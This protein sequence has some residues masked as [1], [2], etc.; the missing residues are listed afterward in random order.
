MIPT[1][2]VVELISAFKNND[3]NLIDTHIKKVSE[4]AEK[5][6]QNKLLQKLKKLY[7]SNS[8]TYWVSWWLIWK[9]NTTNN[10]ILF[11]RRLSNVKLENIILSNKNKNII[12]EFINSYEKRDFFIEQWIESENKILLYWPP[13][14]WKTLFAYS[15]AW[16]LDMPILHV[17][18]DTLISSYLWETGKNI[19][20]IFEKANN[21]E[22]ILFIDEFDSI[23]KKRDDIQELWELKRVVTVL[24]QNIDSL[25]NNTILLVATNHEHLLDSAIWRRF[26]YQ[27]N[28]DNLDQKARKDLIKLY[29]WKNN[30]NTDYNLLAFIS[31]WLSGS[32]IK[33]L[34]NK[35]IRNYIIGWK[36]WNINLFL[37]ESLISWS[38]LSKINYKDNWNKE[39]LVNMIKKLREYNKKVY[40]FNKLEELTWIPHS[41]LNNYLKS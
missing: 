3:K 35:W 4:I 17:H 1:S 38:D 20:E 36:K 19:R 18:L 40:T 28:I 8:G 37:I 10:S 31:N 27:L 2:I 12:E 22:C 39:S 15:L 25:S 23:A 6:W 33:Q 21:E 9:Q 5:K 11:E 34:I 41:T 14:T 24:L 26:D 29:L 16:E 13:G 32:L 30:N 7:S